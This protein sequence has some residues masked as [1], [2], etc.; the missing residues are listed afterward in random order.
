LTGVELTCNL[1]KGMICETNASIDRI[2]A[3]GNYEKNN[4][5]LVCAAVNRLRTNMSV[6][7][8]IEW[9]RKVVTYAIR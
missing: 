4:V 3:G 5:Q 2:L 9:C 1:N 6:E 8:F 7:E